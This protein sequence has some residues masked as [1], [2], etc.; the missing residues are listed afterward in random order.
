MTTMAKGIFA[1][2]ERSASD[3]DQVEARA[4]IARLRKSLDEFQ[5]LRMVNQQAVRGA[6]KSCRF[7]AEDMQLRLAA[8]RD[9]A[10]ELRFR[11]ELYDLQSNI[12]GREPTQEEMQ[13]G[14]PPLGALPLL[15]VAGTV[16]SLAW[17]ASSVTDYL[18]Q[19]ERFA[20]GEVPGQSGGWL[21]TF[22]TVVKGT[23]L[24]ATVG[25][26][27][28]GGYKLMKWLGKKPE[29]P[30]PPKVE[31]AEEEEAEETPELLEAAEEMTEEVEE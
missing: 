6:D 1:A 8:Y 25:V 14:P 31:K 30:K 23:V 22:G 11:Q 10:M 16:A 4:A 15:A 24:V 29:A 26:T 7:S 28:Y 2:P 5:R 20:R 17:G 18:A 21:Q 12:Y 27:G 9:P 19:R 3:V 13:A